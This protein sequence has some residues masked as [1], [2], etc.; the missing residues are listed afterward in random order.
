MSEGL[1][2]LPPD[3]TRLGELFKQLMVVLGERSSGDSLR[4]LAASGL[5]MPQMITLHL[6]A[7]DGPHSVGAI[8]DRLLLSRAATSHLVDRLV[9]ERL[10]GRTE[11]K[12][13]RRHKRVEITY[14]GR[15]LN[16]RL[17]S[18]RGGE[19]SELLARLPAPL[20]TELEQ[21][22]AQ[23]IQKLKEQPQAKPETRGRPWQRSSS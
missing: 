13:D 7:Q 15:A 10:V 20:Q 22:L 14:A 23:V 12:E 17:A 11:D 21:V 18:A 1:P 8:A 5:T 6:L 3:P 9:K 19:V 4:I 2:P 16:E